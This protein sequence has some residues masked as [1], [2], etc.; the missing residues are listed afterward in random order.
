MPAATARARDTERLRRPTTAHR[1]LSRHTAGADVAGTAKRS[2]LLKGKSCSTSYAGFP[3][4][5]H[6][7]TKST[8]ANFRRPIRKTIMGLPRGPKDIITT[9]RR[10]LLRTPPPGLLPSTP[11]DRTVAATGV[12]RSEAARSMAAEGPEVAS[13]AHNGTLKSAM[14]EPLLPRARIHLMPHPISL[15]TVMPKTHQR[16]ATPRWQAAITPSGPRKICKSKTP[17][18]RNPRKKTRCLPPADR[19]RPG[20]NPPH[21]I[22]L[23]LV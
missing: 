12:A 3:L 11:Q 21:L 23:V 16:R 10:S 17:A 20:R 9:T 8:A 6:P 4:K 2:F 15:L 18:R 7:L 1:Q 22:S 5:I 13:R 14:V 19:L